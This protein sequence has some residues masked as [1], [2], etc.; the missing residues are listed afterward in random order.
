MLRQSRGRQAVDL[1][2]TNF[3]QG[4]IVEGLGDGSGE[5][6]AVDGQGAAGGNLIGV[7]GAHDP[8]RP[9][10]AFRHC[11]SP[12]ALLAASSER[13][14]LEHTSSGGRRYDVPRSSGRGASRAG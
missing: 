4:V 1:G 13:N 9:A 5:S 11:S 10:G 14:E 7:G 8:A 12:T 6:V 3:N 2:A